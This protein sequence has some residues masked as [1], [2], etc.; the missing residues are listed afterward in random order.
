MSEQT[1][2]RVVVLGPDTP[3]Y[4]L[5]Q[6]VEMMQ[7]MYEYHATLHTDWEPRPGWQEGSSDW[8][9]GAAGSDDYFFAIAYPTGSASQ[10]IA[11]RPAGYIIGSFHYEAP[12][13]VHHRFGYIADLWSEEAYRTAGVGNQLLASAYEWFKDQGV[14]R[15]QIEVDVKNPGGLKFW[16]KAGFEPFEIVMRKNLD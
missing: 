10:E 11:D 13:F 5:D 15:V 1:N 8:I 16:E 2:F 12:L 6:F 9:S 3:K 14:K 7:R 4:Q